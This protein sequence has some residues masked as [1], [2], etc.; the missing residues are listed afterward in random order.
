MPV[1]PS[2]PPSHPVVSCN[3]LIKDV[4]QENILGKHP[5]EI[6]DIAL[7]MLQSLRVQPIE[8][9]ALLYRRMS[10]PILV[11]NYSYVVPDADLN[12]ASD[13][14]A[15]T[16][17]PVSAP[18][19]FHLKCFGNFCAQGRFHRI[20]TTT[21]PSGVQHI[22]LYPMSFSTL[23]LAD[24]IE[25]SPYHLQPSHCST[26]LVPCPSAVYAS[27][28]RMMSLYSQYCPTRTNLNSDLSELTGY[29]LSGLSG[30]FVDPEDEGLWE[31][32]KIDQ[33]IQEAGQLV[34]QW[35]IEEEWRPGEEWIVDALAAV[36]LGADIGNLPYKL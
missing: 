16:G 30:G 1:S 25:K 22:V 31:D 19:K 10:V 27:L 12:R 7:E 34:R 21:L 20:T 26:I 23:S 8:W 29:N 3:R 6:V 13:L 32:M 14:L 36:A 5:A 9:R 17:L 2:S 35:S 28:I 4:K 15:R 11:P 33:R 24:L 18:T